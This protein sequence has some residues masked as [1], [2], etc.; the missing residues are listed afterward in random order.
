MI[1]FQHDN[2]LNLIQNDII[3]SKSLN[4]LPHND[5]TISQKIENKIIYEKSKTIEEI[6]SYK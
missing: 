5:A 4:Y 3:T 1:N 2:Q 6:E